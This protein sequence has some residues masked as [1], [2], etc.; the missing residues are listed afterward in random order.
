MTERALKKNEPLQKK[1]DELGEDFREMDLGVH[2]YEFQWIF[3]E[4]RFL[5]A[6]NQHD[7]IMM[8]IGD[9]LE[10]LGDFA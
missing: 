10:K 8:A 1:Q 6:R 4:S 3:F 2:Q 9:S 5:M 7:T